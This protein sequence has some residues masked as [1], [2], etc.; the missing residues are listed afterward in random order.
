MIN[1]P[2]DAAGGRSE[3]EGGAGEGALRHPQEPRREA[4]QRSRREGQ[5]TEGHEQ[6]SRKTI[7]MQSDIISM[8]LIYQACK[9]K[10]CICRT[11]LPVHV[12]CASRMAV[13]QAAL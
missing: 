11:S 6:G 12:P 2:G 8:F 9:Q 5:E 4:A 10:S 13:K 1:Q 7:P 3:H